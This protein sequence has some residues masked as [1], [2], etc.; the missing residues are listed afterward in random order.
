MPDSRKHERSECNTECL[1]VS[2]EGVEHNVIMQNIS[3]GGALLKNLQGDNIEV[4][5]G[6]SLMVYES[7]PEIEYAC[8]IIRKNQDHFAVAFLE[9]Q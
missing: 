4:N 2:P 7:S 9:G 3:P 8:T 6:Y 5:M 1:L